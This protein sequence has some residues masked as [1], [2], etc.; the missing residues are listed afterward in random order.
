MEALHRSQ[1]RAFANA[2]APQKLYKGPLRD[3]QS[4][5][6][7]HPDRVRSTHRY[8]DKKGVKRF[9]GNKNLKPTENYPPRFGLRLVELHDQV[10]A[11]KQGAPVL[12]EDLPTAIDTFTMMTCDD[13]WDDAKMIECIRYIRGGTSL[14]IPEAFRDL[15]PAAL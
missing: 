9:H 3:W 4:Y 15:L 7:A 14:R 1:H 5:C 12:P 13:M 11:T 10:L 8:V 2:D 6:S